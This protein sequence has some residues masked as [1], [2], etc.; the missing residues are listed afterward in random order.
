YDRLYK[1][2]FSPILPE[3]EI[4]VTVII[5]SALFIIVPISLLFA[6][7]GV[8]YLKREVRNKTQS[9]EEEIQERKW[10]EQEL[11]TERDFSKSL[12][13]TAQTVILVLNPDGTINSFNPYME[14][15]SGYR[16]EEV[17]GKDWF[18]IFLPNQNRAIRE[19]FKTAINDIQ[20]QE[21]VHPIV[22]KDGQER[23]I[24]WYNET[25]KDVNGK[26]LGL[27]SIGQDITEKR[28]IQNKLEEMALHDS[29]TGLYNRKVLE[30]RLMDNIES[31]QRHRYALSILMLDLDH[32]KQINDNYGHLEGDNVL[33]RVA[34]ILKNSIRKK[35]FAARYG[36]EEFTIVLPETPLHQAQD[37]AERLRNNIAA[38]EF[39]TQKG[40]HIHI[41]VSIGAA[42]LSS[43]IQSPKMLIQRADTALYSAKKRG[44][45][46]VQST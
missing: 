5:Q 8:W 21:N 18:E 17:Q 32:F 42:C 23:Y 20:T 1:K 36:G 11:I 38:Q 19:L 34:D 22:T 7:L 9:L 16:L 40:D 15:I 37:L 27:L 2:W 14:K 46:Q 12:I 39:A 6:L 29:L 30:E 45:N 43:Y 25:L 24:E 41:T 13:E 35:D 3:V 31:A 10:M 26:V 28:K 4:P 33:R 44:R